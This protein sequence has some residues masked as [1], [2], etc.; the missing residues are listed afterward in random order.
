[1]IMVK[2]T[3]KVLPRRASGALALSALALLAV[4]AHAQIGV[5][6]PYKLGYKASPLYGGLDERG[7]GLAVSAFVQLGAGYEDNVFESPYLFSERTNSA[8]APAKTFGTEVN[9]PRGGLLSLAKA[10]AELGASFGDDQR[11]RVLAIGQLKRLGE[12]TGGF[13]E[14]LGEYHAQL[15]RWHNDHLADRRSVSLYVDYRNDL[16]DRIRLD[17]TAELD[18]QDGA[19]AFI[20]GIEDVSAMD[21]VTRL[22]GSV[23]ASLETVRLPWIGRGISQVAGMARFYDYGAPNLDAAVV[24][25]NDTV[26]LADLASSS[27][28]INDTLE[29]DYYQLRGRLRHTQGLYRG[30]SA[31]I[32]FDYMHRTYLHQWAKIARPAPGGQMGAIPDSVNDNPDAGYPHRSQHEFRLYG[33]VRYDPPHINHARINI[34]VQGLRV[35][36]PFEGFYGYDQLGFFGSAMYTP[37]PKAYLE[38]VLGIKN[39]AYHQLLANYKYWFNQLDTAS[40]YFQNITRE[41]GEPVD[42]DDVSWWDTK[43]HKKIIQISL[44]GQVPLFSG[45]ALWGNYS[46]EAEHTNRP[47]GE[48]LSRSFVNQSAAAGVTVFLDVLGPGPRYVIRN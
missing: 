8:T 9:M 43:L 47:P 46:L 20:F 30:Y 41:N 45:L 19:S 12:D 4:G 42:R 15:V 32:T 17:A 26:T 14:T 27:M 25:G 18:I 39:R 2:K 23:V 28:S 16:Q 38:F 48:Y 35:S 21:A 11:L 34:G 29:A 22:R 44:R 36:D 6:G 31:R 10:G 13:L 24:K 5:T 7:V 40:A 33:G 1:M 3:L 37:R